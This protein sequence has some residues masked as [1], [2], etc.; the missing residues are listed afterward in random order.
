MIVRSPLPAW[1]EYRQMALW[2]FDPS[3]TGDKSRSAAYI[4][5]LA[6]DKGWEALAYTR[7]GNYQRIILPTYGQ[8]FDWVCQTLGCEVVGY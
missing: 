5:R 8:A 7:P 2:Y 3:L 1:Y 4:E 6:R